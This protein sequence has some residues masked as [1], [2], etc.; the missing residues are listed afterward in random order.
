MPQI[1]ALGLGTFRLKDQ[2]VIDSVRTG[3]E[4]GYRHIDTAQIYGNEAE[5]GQAIAESGVP[6]S[7]L[8]VTTKIWTD[9]LGADK[10]IPSLEESL[11]KLRLEQVDLTLIHWPSPNDELQVAEYMAALLEAKAAGLTALI[12]VSNFTNAHLQQAMEVVG[13][14]QIATHQV[15]IHPF[16]QNRKVVAFARE[17]GVHLTA[18]M[19]LAYGKV[20]TDPVIQ[21]IAAKHTA[22]PAQVALA[23]ALQQGFAVIPSS[24]KRAN[25][26]SN[27]GALKLTLSEQDMA[28]IAK[29]ERGERLAN[30]GFAP[31]WD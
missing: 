6:R 10:L 13:A 19:P 30:P 8:F 23:W 5:V 26:E 7:E 17:H 28:A 24:T 9:N 21:D 11:R 15:E 27:L 3:L 12:G 18:Y 22:N 25:L 4:L 2:Q 14:D 29:L 16:L 20:M 1:P 31:H